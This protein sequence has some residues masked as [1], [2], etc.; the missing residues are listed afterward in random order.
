MCPHV[1][2]LAAVQALAQQMLLAGLV[3]SGRQLPLA[4]WSSA[5]QDWPWVWSVRHVP[6]EQKLP[7][8]Q[9]VSRLHPQC[10]LRQ[11]APAALPTQLTA[12]PPQWAGSVCRF[13]QLV[14]QAVSPAG[15]LF[16]HAPLEHF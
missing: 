16:T 9:S 14:P 12:Q 6:P 2:G 13:T 10:P 15:Q 7:L 3:S 8:A 1:S 4:H 11:A 5:V